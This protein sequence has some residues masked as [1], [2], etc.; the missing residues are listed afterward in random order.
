M[1]TN[2]FTSI[3]QRFGKL[4]RRKSLVYGAPFLL[5]LLVGSFGLEQFASLRYEFRK[6]VTL[7]PKTLEK[8][9]IEKKKVTLEEE[10]EKIKEVDIDSWENI[11]GPR[12][13]EEPQTGPAQ[14]F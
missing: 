4:K 10:Y 7:D 1:I 3:V 6:N 12:P 9:G 13:W 14:K 11:R 8:Y 2:F 5:L